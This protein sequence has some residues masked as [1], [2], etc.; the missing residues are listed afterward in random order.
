MTKAV[1]FPLSIVIVLVAAAAPAQNSYAPTAE[2]EAVMREADRIVL[3]QKLNAASIAVQQK[4]LVAAAKLYEEAYALV[5]D[6]GRASIPVEASQTISG[7]VSVRL[8]LGREAYQ[9]GDLHQADV[10]VSRALTVEPQNPDAIMLKKEIDLQIAR[11]RGQRPDMATQ[12]EAPA[13]E[14]QK[15]D[16]ATLAR[17][18]QMLYEMGK[19]EEA[20]AKLEQALQLDPDNRGAYYYL[21]LTKQAMYA[22]ED[23]KTAIDNDDRMVR[24]E[25]AWEA[26]V[27]AVTNFANPYF[28]T[29]LVYT[30]AGRQEIYSK[31]NEIHL[32]NVSYQALPLSEVL[33]DLREKALLR[34]PEK[35][36]IN[37]IFN[38]NIEMI[39]S[40]SSVTTPGG[41]PGGGGPGGEQT[42]INPAT[43]LPV[44]AAAGP[45]TADDTQININLTLNNVSLADLLNAICLVSDHPIKYSVEDW[46]VVFSEK[47]PDAPQ[48]EMRTFKVDPNTFYAGLQNVNSF[49]FGSVQITS[50]GAGGGG[51]SGAGGNGQSPSGAV[52]PVVDVSPGASQA[53]AA[54]GGAG[55]GAGGATGTTGGN[56]A[57]AGGAYL[58]NGLSDL[59]AR[60]EDTGGGLLYVTTPNLT[61]DV[62]ALAKEFFSSLGVNLDPPKTVFFND[63]LGVLF[64]Y[65]TPQDLDIIERAI[66]VLN[67]APPMVHIKARFIDVTQSDSDAL[68][69]DWYL[70]G[71]NIGNSVVGQ[72]GN[73]GSLS[74]PASAANPEGTFPG[75]P[76]LGTT[77]PNGVQS[78]TAG[79]NNGPLAGGVPAIATVTGILTNPNF[80]VV[81]HALEQRAGT[82]ELAEPEVT[83]ISGRQTEMRATVIQPVVTGYNFQAAPGATTSAGVP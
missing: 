30:G 50:G 49:S 59:G 52:V 63:R 71:F 74:V 72:G 54:S 58:Q 14:N 28:M 42:A 29:N 46:G 13:I 78:L 8:E 4:D 19:L 70:G 69:F 47:G 67:E 26:P 60:V 81:L 12:E 55:G 62:S 31:L 44:Q 24:V 7:L 5:L 53:R 16:A 61:R 45:Q 65:A 79:I 15:I 83:T 80:Q 2:N 48:Y 43:G 32:D 20:Q 36:G 22:R 10:Q 64:V 39:P 21:S 3:S 73:A 51:S 23:R 33:R 6:I 38:P 75:N 18:G 41:G 56:T 37:F 66:Q 35:Q 40:A 77:I 17:D 57:G 25:R 11:M 27:N 82:H 68:G 9:R 76:T 34:D 1:F